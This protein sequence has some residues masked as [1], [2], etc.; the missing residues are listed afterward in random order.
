M[1]PDER[2]KLHVPTVLTVL[3]V[4]AATAAA[5]A[6]GACEGGQPPEQCST[7]G[8]AGSTSTDECG[9]A[10]GDGGATA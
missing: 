6:I 7:G 5:T 2:K 1:P 4:V 10:A 9:G 8:A 3:T